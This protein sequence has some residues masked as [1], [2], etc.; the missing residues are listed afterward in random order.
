[1][2]G[3]GKSNSLKESNKLHNYLSPQ[4][5]AYGKIIIN[6]REVAEILLCNIKV[7]I[8]R[9]NFCMSGTNVI[10]TRIKNTQGIGNFKIM[11]VWDRFIDEKL[12]LKMGIDT[13]FSMR[14]IQDDPNSNR[15]KER[16]EFILPVCY[17]TGDNPIAN[18]A[19]NNFSTETYNF[20]FDDSKIIPIHKISNPSK[21]REDKSYPEIRSDKK[22]DKERAQ[23][24][25]FPSY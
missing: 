6:N 22:E 2:N 21:E 1:M 14:F 8:N 19:F 4:G 9:E 15:L 12:S 11:K 3:A 13:P 16:T 24:K 18:W 20:V 5:G 10:H 23:R 7:V 25:S 17:F